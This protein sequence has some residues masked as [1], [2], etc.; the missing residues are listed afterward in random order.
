MKLKRVNGAGGVVTRVAQSHRIEVCLVHRPQY[1]DWTFPK[2]RLEIGETAEKAA[3]REV[4]EE[5]GVTAELHPNISEKTNYI[6]G[7]GNDK[8][9]TYFLMTLVNQS[10]QVNN[11]VD[12]YIWLVPTLASEKLSFDRDRE[13]LSAMS[14]YLAE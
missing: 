13:V 14:P 11:E 12:E 1:D 4:F 6:D 3:I 5:A 7:Q 10:F 2:G 8:F 9:V